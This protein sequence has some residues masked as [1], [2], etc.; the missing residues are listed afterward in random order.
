MHYEIDPWRRPLANQIN[1]FDDL[2]IT[3]ND[4]SDA[5]A[6]LDPYQQLIHF[7]NFVSD[8]SD[9]EEAATFID[10]ALNFTTGISPEKA[11]AVYTNRARIIDAR[12]RKLLRSR[13]GIRRLESQMHDGQLSDT[14]LAHMLY[15]YE[16]NAHDIVNDDPD[17]DRLAFLRRHTWFI[18]YGEL[19]FAIR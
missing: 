9:M 16:V 15:A 13:K 1:D 7:K 12:R 14:R 18:R 5:K 19:G 17:Y 3:I 11:M 10:M 4:L 6:Q 8:V 2:V